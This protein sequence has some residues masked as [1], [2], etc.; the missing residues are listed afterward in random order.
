MGLFFDILLHFMC[1]KICHVYRGFIF[2]FLQCFL[3]SQ[4]NARAAHMISHEAVVRMTF[5][6]SYISS[7]SENTNVFYSRAA[8]EMHHTSYK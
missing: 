8:W 2:K 7:S 4:M 5:D 6:G 1:F 3:L